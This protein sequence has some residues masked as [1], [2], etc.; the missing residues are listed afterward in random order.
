MLLL[1]YY[2]TMNLSIEEKDD[3]TNVIEELQSNPL[4]IPINNLDGNN[5][6][7]DSDSETISITPKKKKVKRG[8]TIIDIGEYNVPISSQIKSEK[9]IKKILKQEEKQITN[10]LQNSRGNLSSIMNS[11]S[12]D[13]SLSDVSMDSI[14]E[15]ENDL[16]G[17]CLLKD[18]LEKEIKKLMIKDLNAKLCAEEI[19]E[20]VIRGED[21]KQKLQD[22][23]PNKFK[24]FSRKIRDL[25]LFNKDLNV[26]METSNDDNESVSSEE[27]ISV[28]P[29]IPE[30]FTERQV[31]EYPEISVDPIKE[32]FDDEYF[33]CQVVSFKCKYRLK[34]RFQWI[35]YLLYHHYLL[36]IGKNKQRSVFQRMLKIGYI[37]CQNL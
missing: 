33:E 32:P 14:L 23:L 29:D 12:D 16:Q 26:K 25:G 30:K 8:K 22:L 1:Y 24:K 37:I 9:R 10:V 7:S 35:I 15:K 31:I 28:N 17:I 20:M 36:L 34:F 13:G 21:W 6:V 19:L 2:N 3:F 11:M 5:L 4:T 18:E 27:T